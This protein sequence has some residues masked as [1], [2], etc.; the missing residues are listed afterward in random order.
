MAVC[1]GP[2]VLLCYLNSK[3]IIGAK[4][5]DEIE[6]AVSRN[7]SLAKGEFFLQYY[8]EVF[9][10]WVDIP[11]NYVPADKEKIMVISRSNDGVVETFEAAS[12]NMV[13]QQETPAANTFESLSNSDSFSFSENS[14]AT[15]LDH[16][17]SY[18]EVIPAGIISNSLALVNDIDIT[19]LNEPFGS[20]I[21]EG[22]FSNDTS[23]S[24][25]GETSLRKGLDES[26][27]SDN[28]V[29]GNLLGET[30]PS[31][32]SKIELNASPAIITVENEEDHKIPS[33]FPFP[34]H[35]TPDIEIGL[36][37]KNLQPKLQAKFFTRI[38]NVMFMYTKHPKTLEY[39]EVVRQIVQKYPFLVSPLD[40]EGHGHIIKA[41]RDRFREFRR[42]KTINTSNQSDVKVELKRKGKQKAKISGLEKLPVGEDKTSFM[43]HNKLLKME[44]KK[45]H[46]NMVIVSEAMI[47]SFEM[48]RNDMLTNRF[49]KI[50]TFIKN[51]LTPHLD[52][53]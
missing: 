45:V 9:E 22:V 13:V 7:F 46:P 39:Q 48:R 11:E 30:P 6:C 24:V 38:A 32:K 47:L 28:C 37:M 20:L 27:V 31:K 41:L 23:E 40:T 10:E 1:E 8:D 49:I 35:Y 52:M 50:F 29:S 19:M 26:V 34:K 16:Q 4:S 3:K 44:Y 12:H 36:K 18:S 2:R 15:S 21:E 25:L 51:V 42:S 14:V 53:R 43:R 17:A 33:P 5:S